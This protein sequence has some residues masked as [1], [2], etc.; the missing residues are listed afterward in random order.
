MRA[1]SASGTYYRLAIQHCKEI[2]PPWENAASRQVKYSTSIFRRLVNGKCLFP[3]PHTIK[4]VRF[5]TGGADGVLRALALI[6]LSSSSES[7]S[8]FLPL[9][10]SCG[11]GR[12]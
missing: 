1:A 10:A 5:I 7:V 8:H 11:H 12:A 4:N 9:P 3:T 2:P 6:W